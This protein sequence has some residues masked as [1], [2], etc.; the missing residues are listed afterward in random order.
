MD[1]SKW[2]EYMDADAE[3]EPDPVTETIAERV[4]ARSD[5]G[6]KKYGTSMLRE[7]LDTIQWIDHAIEEALDLAVYLERL[8]FDVATMQRAILEDERSAIAF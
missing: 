2:R 8:K 6:M 1:Y 4:R 3:Q 7:D 5:E